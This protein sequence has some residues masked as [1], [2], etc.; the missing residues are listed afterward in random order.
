MHARWLLEIATLFVFDPKGAEPVLV[1]HETSAANRYWTVSRQR[2]E[3]WQ[4]QL[5]AH[6][7]Q[8]ESAGASRRVQLW[9]EIRPTLEEVFLSDV[10]A[11]VIAAH[12][13]RLESE[14]SNTD[15]API[16]HSV[17]MTQED[18]RN[19]CLRLLIVPGLPVD[20][21]VDLNRIRFGLE[22][23]TDTFLAQL[24]PGTDILRFCFKPD[25]TQDLIA[26][27]SERTAEQ[28][29]FLAWQLMASSCQDWMTKNCTSTSANPQC[30]Q[31]VGEAALAMLHPQRFRSLSPFPSLSSDR[32]N[33]LIDQA[34]LWVSRL[35][36]SETV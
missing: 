5:S 2:F 21:A 22:H 35:L 36:Y 6:R 19:R 13:A 24:P 4:T 17:H 1:G 15:V 18:I 12:G 28:A 8:V 30:N 16:A 32:I 29:N 11:R 7:D 20:Q 10:L 14:G 27:A 25:R 31:Q 26:E 34:D 3:R 9:K 23:W 33:T